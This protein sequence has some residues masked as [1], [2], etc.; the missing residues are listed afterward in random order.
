MRDFDLVVYGATGFTGR[1]TLRVLQQRAPEL[2]I[3]AAGRNPEKLEALG[4]PFIVADSGDP[5]SV[6]AMVARARVLVSTAG[7]F[8]RYGDPVVDA[9]VAEGTHYCDITGETPWV[10]GVIDRLHESA[11][12]AGVR[13]VP[14]CGFDS[15]PSELGA[16]LAV[17][18]FGPREFTGF[19]KI[20]GGGLNGGSLASALNMAEAY[21]RSTMANPF[22]LNPNP[23]VSRETWKEHADPTAPLT[24]SGLWG[25][26]WV[27][28]PIN[29]RVVRRSAALLA[30]GEGFTYQELQ[31]QKNSRTAWQWTMGLGA[32]VGLLGKPWGRRII[33]RVGPEPGDGPTEEQMERGFARLRVV[34][35][36]GRVT[37]T[38]QGDAGNRI[39][40]SILAECA[41]MLAEE[42]TTPCGVVTPSVA[43]G[44]P[45]V[46]RLQAQGHLFETTRPD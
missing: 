5:D 13:L 14:F 45:L 38:A 28:G 2:R 22:L 40:C 31:E 4:G 30:Y 6:R 9:C 43:F 32:A 29:T 11:V 21:P 18:A 15:V 16:L 23:K 33:R 36:E 7:P 12:K 1:Q 35:N 25:S 17:Q 37:W 46:E 24:R 42:L 3:A 39:T 20:A 34:C 41:L 19:M 27:M 10:R 8:G 44:L 26:P